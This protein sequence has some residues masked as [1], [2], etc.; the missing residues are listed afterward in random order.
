MFCPMMSR[1]HDTGTAI[2]FMPVTCVKSGCA[3]WDAGQD[4]CAVKVIGKELVRRRME[5][6]AE[7]YREELL[8]E[9]RGER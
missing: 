3:W 2:H 6:E 5:E 8:A 7:R 9:S 4:A 1:R